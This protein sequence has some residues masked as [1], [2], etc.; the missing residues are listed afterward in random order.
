M[1][2]RDCVSDYFEGGTSREEDTIRG[3]K[4][5]QIQIEMEVGKGSGKI[6]G[7]QRR[8]DNREG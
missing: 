2:R 4:E 3:K 7:K 8:E 5:I 6:R 1:F